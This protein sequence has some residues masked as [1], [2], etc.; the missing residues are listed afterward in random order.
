MDH[1]SDATLKVEVDCGFTV[2]ECK[3][4]F[5]KVLGT[6][7]NR[8]PDEVI[9]IHRMCK[10]NPFVISVIATNLKRYKSSIVRWK[11]WKNLLENNKSTSCPDLRRPIEESLKDLSRS[12]ELLMLRLESLVIFTDNVNIPMKVSARP[13]IS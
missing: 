12:N 8:L 13:H 6:P 1:F 4:L 7:I 9:D 10:H 11:Y 3:E 5:S 2:F